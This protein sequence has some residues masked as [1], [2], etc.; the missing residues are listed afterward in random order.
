LDYDILKVSGQ[1]MAGYTCE[2]VQIP[3]KM[4]LESDVV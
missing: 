1:K 3:F 4:S 2:L